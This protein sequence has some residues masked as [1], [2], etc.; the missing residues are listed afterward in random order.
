MAGKQLWRRPPA[1][2]RWR[3]LFGA[4][5]LLAVAALGAVRA[6]PSPAGGSPETFCERARGSFERTGKLAREL[7][8]ALEGLDAEGP[9][10]TAERLTEIRQ[11]FA[12]EAQLLKSGPVPPGAEEV[13]ARGAATLELL[14]QIADPRLV[15]ADED[16]R[17]DL[18]QHLRDQLLAARNEARAAAAA[19]RQPDGGCAAPRAGGLMHLLGRRTR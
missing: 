16:D 13:Q 2:R 19:M 8:A 11:G 7:V 1:R 14:M 10:A 15:D 17:A 18:A 6:L 5:L 9:A 4:L 12:Q 3:W